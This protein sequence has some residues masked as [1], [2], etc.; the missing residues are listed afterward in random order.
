MKQNLDFLIRYSAVFWLLFSMQLPAKEVAAGVIPVGVVGSE[1]FV[2]PF[3][4]EI[5]GISVAL[6]KRIA[7][8]NEIQ[9]R[10]VRYDKIPEA[11]DAAAAGEVDVLIGP[12]SITKDRA[13]KVVFSQPYYRSGMGIA[14]RS[15][16]PGPWEKLLPFIRTGFLILILSIIPL[17]LV[18]GILVWLA[19]RRTNSKH[20][21]NNP[22]SGITNGMWF[23]LVTMTTVGYGDRAPQTN[24]GRIISGVW[25][26]IAVIFMSSLTAAVTA[27]LTLSGMPTTDIT[28]P[29]DLQRRSVAVIDG[30][31]GVDVAMEYHAKP[32]LVA[33]LDAAL[34]KLINKEADAV[35]FDRTMLQYYLHQNKNLSAHVIE[36]EFEQQNYGLAFPFSNRDFAHKTNIVLLGMLERDELDPLIRQWTST[37]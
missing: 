12:I 18:V 2:V 21:P 15:V 14:V 27:S 32:I 1:P 6:W 16:E 36:S 26:L 13:E 29:L 34:Q 10:L 4:K 37:Q 19:E 25:M 9:Y 22:L 17:L 8:L 20:F 35:L 3:N 7:S 30:S 28:G 5:G 24:A 33:D 23:A 31:T 11:I